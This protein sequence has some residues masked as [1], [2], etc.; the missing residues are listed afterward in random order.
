MGVTCFM[1]VP[2][3]VPY[4]NYWLRSSLCISLCDLSHKS[5]IAFLLTELFNICRFKQASLSATWL[6]ITFPPPR[7]SLDFH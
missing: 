6:C 1:H 4:V 2:A 5:T 3:N 7:K